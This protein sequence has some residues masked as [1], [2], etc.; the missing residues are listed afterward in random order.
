MIQTV[1]Q[2]VTEMLANQTVGPQLSK[3]AVA[4]SAA[5]IAG[6]HRDQ[7]ELLGLI[8]DGQ[9]TRAALS[10]AFREGMAAADA[11]GTCGCPECVAAELLPRETGCDEIS[12]P[13]LVTIRKISAR[14]E[15]KFLGRNVNTGRWLFDLGDDGEPIRIGCVSY[16]SFERE[17]ARAVVE[18]KRERRR[19]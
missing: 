2:G 11:D 19:A 1:S 8:A 3:R 6:A 18:A 7:A 4:L 17:L 16:E 9:A 5:R 14:L 15:V 13:T 10:L 12:T